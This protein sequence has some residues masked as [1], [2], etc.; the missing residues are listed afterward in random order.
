VSPMSS[1]IA[2]RKPLRRLLDRWLPAAILCALAVFFS[3]VTYRMTPADSL[4]RFRMVGASVAVA[5]LAISLCF[6]MRWARW[7]ALGW[8]IDVLGNMIVALALDVPLGSGWS[9]SRWF[10][11]SMAIGAAAILL[12]LGRPAARD[13]FEPTWTTPVHRAYRWTAIGVSICVTHGAVTGLFGMT[14]RI[15]GPVF[16]A[17]LLVVALALLSSARIVGLPFALAG[18]IAF[19]LR[20]D[21][22]IPHFDVPAGLRTWASGT[23]GWTFFIGGAS[24]VAWIPAIVATLAAHGLLFQHLARRQGRRS[25]A[26]MIALLL[27]AGAALGSLALFDRTSR[28]QLALEEFT[29]HS[30]KVLLQVIDDASDRDLIE[31]GCSESALNGAALGEL[32]ERQHPEAFPLVARCLE[33]GRLRGPVLATAWYMMSREDRREITALLIRG[34]PGRMIEFALRDFEPS[35]DDREYLRRLV[36]NHVWAALRPLVRGTQAPDRHLVIRALVHPQRYSRE[37]A[38]SAIE[39]DPADVYLDMLRE[40]S[41]AEY[42]PLSLAHFRALAAYRSAELVPFMTSWADSF[43]AKWRNFHS[44]PYGFTRMLEDFQDPSF[45]PVYWRLLERCSATTASVFE[46]LRHDGDRLRTVMHDRLRSK[47]M[48]HQVAASSFAELLTEDPDD[49]RNAE[50]LISFLSRSNT[51]SLRYATRAAATLM[52]PEAIPLLQEMASKNDGHFLLGMRA[53]LA[54]DRPDLDAF[55]VKYASQ[56]LRE[57]VQPGTVEEIEEI[58]DDKPRVFP[59]LDPRFEGVTE[60]L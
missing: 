4:H 48:L 57:T 8:S 14:Q 25:A 58:M 3:V 49:E 5:S 9:D 59:P 27:S 18:L 20:S 53:L 1:M 15:W 43:C 32:F 34:R 40:I 21:I 33:E 13:R 46:L 51:Y 36:E 23:G 28:L 29:P 7:I 22:P 2:V 31:L 10:A 35:D 55:V 41:V 6:G 39:I 16:A 24:S 54:Y 45:E 44:L 26:T 42:H 12:L 47:D 60:S 11:R 38:F 19:A 17:V 52:I 30:A 50:T 37:A 56:R